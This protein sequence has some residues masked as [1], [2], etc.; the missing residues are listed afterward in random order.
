MGNFMK[1]WL[2]VLAGKYFINPMFRSW[3]FL[4]IYIEIK[5]GSEHNSDPFFL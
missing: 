5:K 2:A 1:L 3:W 4:K